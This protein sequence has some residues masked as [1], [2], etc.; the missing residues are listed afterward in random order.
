VGAERGATKRLRQEAGVDG[1]LAI[2]ENGA[3]R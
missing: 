2:N 3:W 1:M